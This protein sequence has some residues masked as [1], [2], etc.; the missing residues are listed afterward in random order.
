MLD[1]ATNSNWFA[2]HTVAVVHL[3]S[4][5]GV[6]PALSNIVLLSHVEYGAQTKSVVP[7][8]SHC[9][10]M[11]SFAV[12]LVM[13]LH[14]VHSRLLVGVGPADSYSVLEHAEY[15]VHVLWHVSTYVVNSSSV[16]TPLC[17]AA[18]L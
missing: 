9:D 5:V 4:E 11:Y 8:G 10:A 18:K 1:F 3:R 17:M 16:H 7:P 12:Q 6:G 14:A 13:E 2:P 15:W